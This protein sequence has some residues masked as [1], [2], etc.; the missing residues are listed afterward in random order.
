MTEDELAAAEA[1]ARAEEA[2]AA[3]G[4]PRDPRWAALDQ[5][6]TDDNS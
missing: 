4:P 3:G 5:L 2:D 6:K 1:Q